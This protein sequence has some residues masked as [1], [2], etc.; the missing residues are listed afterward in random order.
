MSF[1]RGPKIVRE[2]LQILLD[3]NSDRSWPGSGTTWYD[4]SGNGNNFTFDGTPYFVSGFPTT[5]WGTSGRVATGPASNSVG[6]DNTSGYSIMWCFKTPT[7]SSNGAFKFFRSSGSGT[8]AR[9]IFVHPGWTNDTIYF[10]QGGCCNA[11]TRTQYTNSNIVGGSDWSFA[12]V[13]CNTNRTSRSIYYNGSVGTTNTT[14]AVEINLGSGGIQLNPSDEGYNWAGYLVN[15]M[16]YNRE[17]S[18]DE[19]D[20]NYNAFKHRFGI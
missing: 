12:A 19:L 11:D 20:Q 13:T 8:A 18:T 10:D 14:T 16:V 1:K 3:A 7:G 5:Y 2:N 4:I 6:I 15:F 17:L 9:G